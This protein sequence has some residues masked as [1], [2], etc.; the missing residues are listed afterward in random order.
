MGQFHVDFDL[1]GACGEIYARES[2]FLGKKVYLEILESTVV[3]GSL[4]A[5]EHV[6]CKGVP[7]A[8]VKYAAETA[9]IS[10]LDL[11]KRL[12]DGKPVRFDLTRGGQACGFKY[13]RDLS[14]RSYRDGEFTRCLQFAK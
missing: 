13:D 10:V 12:Y 8:S 6:R 2:L 3:D 11:Y 4:I 5:G 1:P 9:G 7:T 14:V